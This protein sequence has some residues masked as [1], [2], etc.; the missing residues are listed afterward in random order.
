LFFSPFAGSLADCRSKSA[1]TCGIKVFE[2]LIMGLAFYFFYQQN[3][4]AL[5]FV[6]FLM[7]LQSTIF[8]PA[9]YGI[10]PEILSPEYLSKGNGYIQFW[11]FAAIIC[12][13]ALSGV[14]LSFS[15]NSYILP[16]S[17]MLILAALG[18]GS[19]FF[20]TKTK[21]ADPGGKIKLS[22][23]SVI[24]SLKEIKKF[25]NLFL[26]V[27]AISFFWAVSAMYQLNIV[28][29][30]KQLAQLD[31]LRTSLWLAALGVGIGAGSILAG[32]V[33]QGKVEMGLVPIGA[34]GLALC[35]LLLGFSHQ[36]YYGSMLL[37]LGLGVTGGFFIVPLNAY[38]QQQSPAQKRGD[39]IAA[40]NLVSFAGMLLFSFL[41]LLFVDVLN[42]SPAQ[43]FFAI[44]ILS[45]GVTVYICSVVPEFLLRCINWITMHSIYR[46]NVV[47]LSN[48]PKTGGALLVCNH[49]TFVDAP[50]LLAAVDRPIR[51]LMYKPIYEKKFVNPVAK[52]MK[53]I[54]IES[55]KNREDVIAA[56]EL[57]GQAIK[58]GELVGIF[59]EGGISRIARMLKFKKGLE[60]VMEGVDAPIVPVHL[61][62]MWGS[63]F[64]RRGGKFF[65]KTP[66]YIP[67]PTTVSFGKPLPS[68]AKAY[69]VRRGVQEL[70]AEAFKHRENAF[71][72]LHRGFIKSAKRNPLR[73]CMADSLGTKISYFRTLTASLLFSRFFSKNLEDEKMIG[74]YL[75]PHSPRSLSQYR[76]V[77]SR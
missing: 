5:L 55:G 28:L 6:L 10:L 69:E 46:M 60:K 74:I 38:L 48:I 25:R 30:A 1:I 18:L 36:S 58:E 29:Y 24:C 66:R 56:L 70:S 59:P 9:K 26:T 77:D 3:V 21:P 75:P 42:F 32:V 33:S 72:V 7:G 20:V 22:P 62:Q 49:V 67:Y 68:S 34:A 76:P 50:M 43:V 44:G 51:F 65:W 57:A 61:D 19:S 40:A 35:S 31:D 4:Y 54:P 13:T 12:G 39:Y 2:L 14:L 41:L 17:M 53:T 63:I 47:G 71:Q 52:A 64:S 37:L 27:L 8:S 11:T 45:V 73:Q 16:A 15:E 23:T